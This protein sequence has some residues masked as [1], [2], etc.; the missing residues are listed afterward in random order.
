MNGGANWYWQAQTCL[1]FYLR[2]LY[3]LN[4]TKTPVTA[5][6]SRLSPFPR[7]HFDLSTFR[8]RGAHFVRLLHFVHCIL[9]LHVWRSRF[10]QGGVGGAEI[11]LLYIR[12]KYGVKLGEGIGGAPQTPFMSFR[13]SRVVLG[14]ADLH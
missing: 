7:L 10:H 9:L 4:Y 1:L 11:K 14:T 6:F 5:E 12:L 13:P 2:I 3:T 8:A